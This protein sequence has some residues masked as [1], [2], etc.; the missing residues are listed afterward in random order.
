MKVFMSHSNHDK[1]FVEKLGRDLLN[2]DIG[3]W[4]DKWEINVGDS[5]IDK[6]S[7]GL[8]ESDYLV[9]VLSRNSVLS[10]WVSKELN[11]YLMKEIAG[12]KVKILPIIIDNCDI[13][14]FL[15]EKIYAD[16]RDDYQSGL[17]TLVSAITQSHCKQGA[18]IR[19]LNFLETNALN[20]LCME[21]EILNESKK[22]I[23]LRKLDLFSDARRVRHVCYYS[24]PPVYMHTAKYEV[25]IC[26]YYKNDDNSHEILGRVFEGAEDTYSKKVEGMFDCQGTYDNMRWNVQLSIPIRARVFAMDR[27]CLRIVLSKQKKELL[28]EF[29]K[30][31]GERWHRVRRVQEVPAYPDNDIVKNLRVV[32]HTDNSPCAEFKTSN[33]DN[34]IKYFCD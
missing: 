4:L 24:P 5:L 8:S 31:M 32:L 21:I 26:C 25:D 20:S 19:H 1:Q 14:V 10:S 7:D 9:I 17:N 22:E 16:F 13:P 12:K 27:L 6:I 18:V 34:I 3:V 33:Y 23:W 2:Q 11:Y 28:G 29:E 30:N 15:L